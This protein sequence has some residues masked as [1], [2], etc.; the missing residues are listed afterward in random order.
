MGDVMNQE[1]IK[2]AQTKLSLAFCV[3]T[4]T[5]CETVL[6]LFGVVCQYLISQKWR[7]SSNKLLECAF[8]PARVIS[9]VGIHTFFVLPVWER[10][11]HG[12]RS[13]AA[14]AQDEPCVLQGA[15]VSGERISQGPPGNVV[16]LGCPPPPRRVS[17]G[18]VQMLP[19]GLPF[20]DVVLT[21]KLHINPET[22]L[23][24]L[25]PLVEF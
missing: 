15:A 6:V 9:R 5:M 10:T 14:E 16:F 3:F 24:R 22:S 12:Q 4:S 21:V 7:A 23:E 8:I 2:P 11:V 20:Q 13:R 17:E 19:L 18:S 1:A 25:V